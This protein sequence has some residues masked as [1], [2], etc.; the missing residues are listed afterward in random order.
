MPPLIEAIW[1][2]SKKTLI[3]IGDLL[4][5]ITMVIFTER[6]PGMILREKITETKIRY[7][8]KLDPGVRGH[9]GIP[10]HIFLI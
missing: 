7:F 1:N 10:E 4:L 3:L 5:T 6:S 8:S 2:L 9:E